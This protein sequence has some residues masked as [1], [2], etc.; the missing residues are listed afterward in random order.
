MISQEETLIKE[1]S[2][3]NQPIL[4]IFNEDS[5]KSDDLSDFLKIRRELVLSYHPSEG[6]EI[7]RNKITEVSSRPISGGKRLLYILN[8]EM[9]NKE[10]ANTL[11]KILEEPPAHL[12][13]ILGASNLSSV[14]QT[15]RSRCKKISFLVRN[16]DYDR[17]LTILKLLSLPMIEYLEEINKMEKEDFLLVLKKGLEELKKTGLNK[18]DF[19]RF[20]KISEIFKKVY[21]TNIN[22]KLLAERL[23]IREKMSV[24]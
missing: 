18:N 9:L 20:K 6:V 21:S 14:L 10:Q 13:I 15:I 7:L 22:Y 11:L 16:S 8:S 1:F 24:E 4:L 2:R 19:S 5:L 17:D 3:S 23:Y 12:L